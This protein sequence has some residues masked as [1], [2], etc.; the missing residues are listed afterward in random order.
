[1]CTHTLFL[2]STSLHTRLH[3]RTQTS[4][5]RFFI[6]HT[7]MHTVSIALLPSVSLC[8]LLMLT[9]LQ[10]LWKLFQKWATCYLLLSFG[11]FMYSSPNEETVERITHEKPLTQFPGSGLAALIA[12]V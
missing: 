1:M 3:S 12:R 7:P 5:L 10:L 6:A 11:Y 4:L 2:Q 9:H 8:L